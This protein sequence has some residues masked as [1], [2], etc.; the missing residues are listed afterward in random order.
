VTSAGTNSI[1]GWTRL[2][3]VLPPARPIPPAERVV[4]AH[5]VRTGTP[6]TDLSA[7][8]RRVAFVPW[9]TKTDCDHVSVWTPGK[10]AIL[11]VSP[12]VPAPCGEGGV[13]AMYGVA[14]AGPRVAWGEI[15]GC[16]NY[17]DVRVDSATIA[18][19]RAQPV[20]PWGSFSAD[21]GGPLDYHLY[22]DGNLLVYDDETR[23]V[24]IGGGRERCAEGDMAARI[25]STLRRGT[26]AGP[27][28]SASHGLIAIRESDA[29]AIVD[30]QGSLVRTFPFTPEDVSAARLDNGHL[31]VSRLAFLEEYDVATG[32]REV[33]RPL[34][35]GYTLEDFDAGM[36]IA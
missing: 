24:R 16:G 1:L 15:L 7:D 5:E 27:V 3:P 18:G 13:G 19:R 33:S 10:K 34:P 17:C 25:C 4:G 26:H 20:S 8:G 35:A 36:G 29:V 32:L 2:A 6:I 28:D 22:G 9:A 14:L 11:R 23:L 12:S 30:A 21:E 31:A